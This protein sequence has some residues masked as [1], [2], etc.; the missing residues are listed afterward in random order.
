[1]GPINPKKNQRHDGIGVVLF[2]ASFFFVDIGAPHQA[3]WEGGAHEAT[4][5]A[6]RKAVA[7]DETAG[8][9]GN[10]GRSRRRREKRDRNEGQ[11]KKNT[12]EKIDKEP[13]RCTRGGAKGR[14]LR[15]PTWSPSASAFPRRALCWPTSLMMAMV[16]TTR[17]RPPSPLLRDSPRRRWPR[18][19]CAR[20]PNGAL[21]KR[22]SP[23]RCPPRSRV[24]AAGR[25]CAPDQM[26]APLARRRLSPSSRMR[27]ATRR[28]GASLSPPPLLR[29]SLLDSLF[30]RIDEKEKKRIKVAK[31]K[32]QRQSRPALCPICLHRAP[33]IVCWC[34]CHFFSFALSSRKDDQRKEKR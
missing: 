18:A 29:V 31:E 8:G 12:G 13:C 9:D 34:C 17:A 32:R 6:Q 3:I 11:N 23:N 16:A 10:A 20:G 28:N 15:A 25:A 14:V 19:G 26:C 7:A 24:R 1:M 2:F 4:L 27:P 33:A 30:W 5:R 22:P 21:A